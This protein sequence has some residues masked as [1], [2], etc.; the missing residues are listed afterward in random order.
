MVQS[1]YRRTMLQVINPAPLNST[2][3]AANTLY[4]GP[5]YWQANGGQIFCRGRRASPTGATLFRHALPPSPC[6]PCSEQAPQPAVTA[7]RAPDCNRAG[8]ARWLTGA[9]VC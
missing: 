8:T 9:Y 6:L 1:S 5:A 3:T 4:S 7:A 2:N